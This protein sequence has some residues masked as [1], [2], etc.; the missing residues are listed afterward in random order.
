MSLCER[1]ISCYGKKNCILASSIEDCLEKISV[2]CN[3]PKTAL[4]LL[5]ERGYEIECDEVFVQLCDKGSSFEIKL[6]ENAIVGC[7]KLTSR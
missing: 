5:S 4:L 2:K 6:I 7:R 3:L 1:K